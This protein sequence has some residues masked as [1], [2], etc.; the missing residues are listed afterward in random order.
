MTSQLKLNSTNNVQ[1]LIR[2]GELHTIVNMR[3]NDGIFGFAN[4]FAW[5]QHVTE[6]L[7]DDLGVHVGEYIWQAGSLHIYERHFKFLED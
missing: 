5:Q 6:K 7:A 1:Y 4:D 3:S 2:D